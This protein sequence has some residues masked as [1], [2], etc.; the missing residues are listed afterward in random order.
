MTKMIQIRNVP[1]EWHRVLKIRAAEQGTSLSEYLLRE[2]I[3]HASRPSMQEALAAIMR[4]EPVTAGPDGAQII[5]EMREG[6]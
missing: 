5:R 2:V 4:D 1:D 6:R 3:Q